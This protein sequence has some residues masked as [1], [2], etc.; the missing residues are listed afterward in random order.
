MTVRHARL[1]ALAV[2]A[3]AILS[4]G[5]CATVE[6]TPEEI[7][8]VGIADLRALAGQGDLTAQVTLGDL[9]VEGDG[10]PQDEAEA[11]RW[12]RLAAEQGNA[13][14][15]LALGGMYFAG[16]G[17]AED[18]TEG[19]RWW[20]LAAEQGHLPAQTGLAGRYFDGRGVPRD[21]AEAVRWYRMAAEQGDAEVLA[22]L[23]VTAEQGRAEAQHGLGV[24]YAEGRG[25][26]QDEAE[27]VRW[28][29]LA[30][31]QGDTEATAWVRRMA[32][33][34]RAEAQHGLGVMYAEGRGVTQD[35]AEAVRWYR[36][37]AE[38]GLV[39]AQ[40]ALASMY[41]TG[42]G[43]P[44][45]GGEAL[46]WYR[47]AAEQGLVEAQVAL[48]GMYAEGRGIAQDET[49]AV[50][51]YLLAAEQDDN[52]AVTRLRRMVEQGSVE[53]QAALAAVYAVGRGITDDPFFMPIAAGQPA[54]EVCIMEFAT[55][56]NSDGQAARMML[57]VDE[58]GT[59]RLFV[60]DMRG[61]LYSV[62]YDG[63]TVTQYLDLNA[64]HWGVSV[65]SSGF[66]Q[67]FQSFAF[68]PQF[69]E[70]STPGFGKLY[71]LTDTSDTRPP[72][73]F[74]S[75]GNSNSHD[76]VLLE[77]T[78]EHSEAATYDGGP[79]RELVRFEQPFNIHNGGHLAFHPLTS[80][81]DAEFGLL[82]MGV[83]DGGSDDQFFL[84]QNRGSAFGKILRLDPLG[85]NSANGEY[86]IPADNPFANDGDP[87]TLGE[88]YALGVRNPQ[89]FNWDS[90]TGNMFVADI[91]ENVV[92]EVSLVTAG[93]NLGWSD[94]EGSFVV[95]SGRRHVSLAN[96]RGDAQ[97][98]YP[99]VE[100]GQLDPLLQ[101]GS[102]VTGVYVYRATAIPQ[103][104][105]LVLFG[106]NPS[107]EV[108]AFSADN[109][110]AGGQEAIRRILFNNGNGPKT[111]LQLIQEKNTADGQGVATRADM[112]LGL[113][114]NDQMFVLNKRDGT[115]RLLVAVR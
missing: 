53:A 71:T 17:V 72:A 60:N 59:G 108:L 69:H 58:P 77:W 22:W 24:M 29:L 115:I 28:Y 13:E 45:D 103:L 15:Q 62:S 83:A 34:G 30:A 43:L 70:S 90:T 80:P 56:P 78:A 1:I 40:V 25:V 74:A 106:D 57:L 76:T 85:S 68:H 64:D 82:Y 16:R 66:E 95:Q 9:Y 81:G 47:L 20:R 7:R 96:P 10:V 102:A 98:T 44:E 86:G 97:M 38:Q 37:A 92:E 88:V 2:I 8:S 50:R 14:A 33:Q 67:G 18:P 42:R 3:I 109:L 23:L 46:W 48:G 63:T 110:P 61:P 5:A 35:E 107:G 91:G 21:E 54:I 84:A 94:W 55:I 111:V 104:T 89:R 105:N 39:E 49:E 52:E 31:E 41:A 4:S 11:V 32:E 113:G 79:P 114:P 73:D 12:Y 99:V 112:R 65:E 101:P 100:Y 75:G 19:V 27:A 87:D 51:W 26:T 6:L 36:L 93:A